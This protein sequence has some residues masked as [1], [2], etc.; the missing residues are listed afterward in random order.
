MSTIEIPRSGLMRLRGDLHKVDLVIAQMSL[1]QLS[2]QILE[3]KKAHLDS[4]S[5]RGKRIERNVARVVGQK[6]SK[7]MAILPKAVTIMR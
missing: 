7:T 6:P 5:K 1:D 3:L 2:K 4:Q